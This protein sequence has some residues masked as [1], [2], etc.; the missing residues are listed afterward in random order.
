MIKDTTEKLI[1]EKILAE[2]RVESLRLAEITRQQRIAQRHII[3][4]VIL[5]ELMKRH[6]IIGYSDESAITEAYHLADIAID[7]GEK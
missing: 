6:N 4:M 1:K 5:P 2:S 7:R 3:A